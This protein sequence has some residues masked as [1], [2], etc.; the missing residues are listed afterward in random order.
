MDITEKRSNKIYFLTELTNHFSL[1]EG[2]FLTNYQKTIVF[3]KRMIFKI[4]FWKK[5]VFYTEQKI[6]NERTI[7]LNNCSVRKR[8]ILLNKRFYWTIF[9][10]EYERNECK[11]KQNGKS[12]T[13]PSLV[14][15]IS[16]VSRGLPRL[17][18]PTAQISSLKYEQ[19]KDILNNQVLNIIYN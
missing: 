5:I 14:V 19:A 11:K 6:F 17:Y 12:E 8:T 4:K 15:R 1:I 13:C 16:T 9:Q 18:P 2:L 3:T 10:W 7:F